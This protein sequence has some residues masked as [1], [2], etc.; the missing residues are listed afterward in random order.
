[1]I[2]ASR[3]TDKANLC[4]QKSKL[5]VLNAVLNK[6][7]KMWATIRLL[8]PGNSLFFDEERYGGKQQGVT[9]D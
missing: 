2:V 6:C 7:V 3:E 1:L 9:V 5:F 4:E 8:F